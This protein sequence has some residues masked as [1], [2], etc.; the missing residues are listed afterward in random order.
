MNSYLVFLHDFHVYELVR[1][2]VYKCFLSFYFGSFSSAFCFVIN[3]LFLFYLILF[4]FFRCLLRR[5]RKSV[6][7][8]ERGIEEAFRG[9]GGGNT[10]IRI[11]GM[12]K[13]LLLIKER[14][15]NCN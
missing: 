3:C 1:L 5:D 9:D 12:K 15:K 7:C 4:L 11:Y 8:N 2:H 13:N 10:I 6:V 14:G